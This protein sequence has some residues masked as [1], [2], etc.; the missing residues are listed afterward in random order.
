[1]S[2]P[3]HPIKSWD[4]EI[5][6]STN[7]GDLGRCTACH[8]GSIMPHGGLLANETPYTPVWH[9]RKAGFDVTIHDF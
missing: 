1:M 6:G 5:C 9:A 4:C 2:A 7:P 3:M 8:T